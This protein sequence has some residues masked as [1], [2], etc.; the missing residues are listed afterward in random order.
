MNL[1]Y[2]YMN[3]TGFTFYS[4]YCSYG[5][6]Y[7]GS[8]AETGQV[9]LNDLFF[10]YHALFITILTVVQSFIY[11]RGKN[12]IS[13]ITIG[14]LTVLWAFAICYTILTHVKQSLFRVYTSLNLR[15]DSR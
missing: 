6:F 3:L 13:N 5:Y 9:D 2:L 8:S 1:D 7:S 15:A 4:I 10:A 11:P 14:Y 12:K